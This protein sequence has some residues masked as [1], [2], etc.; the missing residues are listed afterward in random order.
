MTLPLCQTPSHSHWIIH[1][2]LMVICRNLRNTPWMT[3]R[4]TLSFI[5][6]LIE[7]QSVDAFLHVFHSYTILRLVKSVD[8]LVGCIVETRFICIRFTGRFRRRELVSLNKFRGRFCGSKWRMLGFLMVEMIRHRS[9]M[10][11]F[12]YLL[13]ILSIILFQSQRIFVAHFFLL[14][15]NH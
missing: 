3:L 15:I 13:L 5:P 1:W 7:K 4:L 6:C 9:F 2:L 11:S 12:H 14:F 8:V 10:V